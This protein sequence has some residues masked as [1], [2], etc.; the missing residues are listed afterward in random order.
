MGGMVATAYL[1][2]YGTQSVDSCVYLCAAHN[3][4]YVAGSALNGNIEIV[5]EAMNNIFSSLA[6]GNGPFVDFLMK[7]PMFLKT[8]INKCMC[9]LLLLCLGQFNFQS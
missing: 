4:T 5:P 8:Y 1:Y 3:G 2:Y 6:S 7:A 9:F